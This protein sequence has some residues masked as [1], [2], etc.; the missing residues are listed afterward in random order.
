MLSSV[1]ELEMLSRQINQAHRS[2]VQA[3]LNAVG[4]GEV[5]HPMLLTIYTVPARMTRIV[6]AMLSET[7]R[8]CCTFRRRQLRLLS[9]PWK[10]EDISVGNRT[11]MPG[12]TA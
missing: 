4:L 10:K 8:S 3:E 12:K 2:A 1:Q 5:G 11:R 9:N 6:N 7:W